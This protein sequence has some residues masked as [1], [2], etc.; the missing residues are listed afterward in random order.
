MSLQWIPTDPVGHGPAQ[1]LSRGLGASVAVFVSLLAGTATEALSQDTLPAAQEPK[2]LVWRQVRN[3]FFNPN[4]PSD[5]VSQIVERTPP[6]LLTIAPGDTVSAQLQRS[7]NVSSTRTP[8]MYE[9]LTAKIRHLN[10]DQNLDKVAAGTTLLVPQIPKAVWRN[11]ATASPLFGQ[12]V[13][14]S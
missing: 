7:F 13:R 3:D 2:V 5:V 6:T 4:V 11:Y 10:E 8:K 14:T 1:H 12:N 9:E